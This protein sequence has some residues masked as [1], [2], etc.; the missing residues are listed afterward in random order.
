MRFV[1][2]IRPGLRV[3][4]LLETALGLAREGKTIGGMIPKNP[5]QLAVLAQEFASYFYLTPVQW[6]MFSPVV[7]LAFFGGLIGYRTKYPKYGG[8]E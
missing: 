8:K 6:A 4:T 7:A 3:E 2:G 1:V 5:L